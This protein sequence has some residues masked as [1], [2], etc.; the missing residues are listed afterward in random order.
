MTTFREAIIVA[1]G[2]L[3]ETKEA[4][5]RAEMR[6]DL[7]KKSL[8]E[9]E[10]R[11]D[12]A[13]VYLERMRRPLDAET[14]R[15]TH[16]RDEREGHKSYKIL[17]RDEN[18]LLRGMIQDLEARMDKGFEDGYFY[19]SLQVAK[20]LPTPYDLNVVFG[21]EREIIEAK[22]ARLSKDVPVQV[23]PSSSD[24]VPNPPLS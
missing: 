4:L 24:A 8:M 22:A 21:W 15:S 16:R 19:A 23:D 18:H 12:T 10:E 3:E 2:E 7:L 11:R 1:M 5:A 9:V 6:N 20:A 14:L 13:L 17:L